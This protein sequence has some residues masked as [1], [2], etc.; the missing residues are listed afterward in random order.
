M[1]AS[2]RDDF[3]PA[4][5][6]SLAERVN[7]L[8][9]NPD[10]RAPTSGP[11]VANSKS[12]N[13]GVAAHITAAAQGGPRY[14]PSLSPDERARATNG[15]WLCQNCAKMV[16][17]DPTRYS[18]ELLRQWK[19]FAEQEAL[20][21]LGKPSPTRP[22]EPAIVD[23]WVNTSYAEKAGIVRRLTEE[24]YELRWTAANKENE[25]V[26]LEGWDPV[27]ISQPDGK[28]ARLKI[29]DHPSMGGY[30]ILLKKRKP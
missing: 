16:D 1:D 10:C 11:Q 26:D 4:T 28:Q 19:L 13:V 20:T 27:L 22:T 15:I 12:M 3:P 7:F 14:E 29:K 21:Q 9:S 25:R 30:L 23:K 24:E 18:A 17:N 2:I 5:K 8:C 6:R